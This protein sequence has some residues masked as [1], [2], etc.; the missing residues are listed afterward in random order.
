MR[1]SN[2]SPFVFRATAIASLGGILFGYDLAVISA[3]LPQITNTFDLSE[4]QQEMLVSFLY[5]GCCFGAMIGGICCDTFGRK[6]TIIITDILFFISASILFA[7]SSFGIVLFGRLLVGAAV[8]ISGIAD[9]AYLHEISPKEYRGAIVSCNEACISLGFLISYLCGYFISIHDPDDGWRYM[10]GLASIIAVIQFICMF[11][12]PESPVW[13]AEKSRTEELNKALAHI[14]SMDSACHKKLDSEKNTHIERRD[15]DTSRSKLFENVFHNVHEGSYSSFNVDDG[16][17]VENTTQPYHDMNS[18]QIFQSHYRQVIIAVFLSIMQQFCGHPNVLNF[19]HEIFGQ[20]G[21][22]TEVG[23]LYSVMLVGVVKFTVTCVVIWKIEQIGRRKLLLSGMSLIA[24]SLLMLTLVYSINDLNNQSLLGKVVA[25]I[26]VFGVAAGYAASFGPLVWL[27]VSELFPSIV[28][29]RALAGSTITSYASAA[30]VS[31]TFLSFQKNFG[32]AVPFGLYFVL[33]TLSI[34]FTIL[35]IPDTANMT[36][37][38]IML[39]LETMWWW[40]RRSAENKF[41]P[42]QTNEMSSVQSRHEI[43]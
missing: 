21:F 31:Y 24:I 11:S 36:S 9:V 33:T 1:A 6:R 38:E 37:E 13:L 22:N 3:A 15:T 23:R 30:L 17:E 8:A 4:N 18:V 43:I 14:H 7:A 41:A 19:S 32:L 35:A 34:A 2:I 28:R 20:I 27:L 12:L 5:V 29:G 26:S 25:S 10:F 39:H 40:R 42:T 16:E